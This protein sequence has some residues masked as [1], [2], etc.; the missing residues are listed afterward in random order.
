MASGYSDL[1]EIRRDNG[2][3]AQSHKPPKI[4]L[5]N[6]R[7]RRE[8]AVERQLGCNLARTIIGEPTQQVQ[9][10]VNY[11]LDLEYGRGSQ[12]YAQ[13][14]FV[15]PIGRETGSGGPSSRVVRDTG[16][17]PRPGGSIGQPSN[18]DPVQALADELAQKE[19]RIRREIAYMNQHQMNP[20]ARPPQIRQ[21]RQEPKCAPA[22]GQQRWVKECPMSPSLSRPSSRASSTRSNT[23]ADLLEKTAKL[24]Q[25][26]EEIEH[27][28]IK[29]QEILIESGVRHKEQSQS[30]VESVSNVHTAVI[31]VPNKEVDNKSPLPF[32]Y[33]NF[34]TLGIRGNIASVGAAP[35]ESPYPPIFPVVKRT[36]SPAN[37]R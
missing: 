30:P 31:K 26:A 8:S 6:E 27:K 16:Q 7:P 3:Y 14:G 13:D 36:P 25:D 29:T 15:S 21:P 37:R 18:R 12:S 32:A 23:E 34:S 11:D 10:Q 28:Q 19:A 24:L 22:K 1:S 9:Q 5:L 33:D 35:P 2:A 20:W 17:E 4:N